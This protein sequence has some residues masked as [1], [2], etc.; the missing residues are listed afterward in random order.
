[1]G[2]LKIKTASFDTAVNFGTEQTMGTIADEGTDF[3]DPEVQTEG[4]A[5]GSQASVGA[6]HNPTLRIL[7]TGGDWLTTLQGYVDDLT[8]IYVR[9]YS[10]NGQDYTQGGPYIVNA[11]FSKGRN[12]D[13]RRQSVIVQL[14]TSAD[15]AHE[16]V[17]N[18]TTAT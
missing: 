5:S 3:P 16:I 1:M 18:G 7:G 6:T 4:V 2:I 14:S 11:A 12:T 8:E 9:V 10:P 15:F 17:S 13:P